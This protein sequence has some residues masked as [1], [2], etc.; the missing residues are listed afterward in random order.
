MF[1]KVIVLFASLLLFS[2]A[3]AT[4]LADIDYSSCTTE[5]LVSMAVAISHEL[6]GRTS[7]NE[8][9]KNDFLYATNQNVCYIRT[10]LGEGG[11][12]VI[13]SQI[14]EVIVTTIIDEAFVSNKSITGVVFSEGLQS[15]GNAAFP[16]TKLTGT[17]TLPT[18]LKTVGYSAF[19]HTDVTSV[20]ILSDCSVDCY[21]FEDTEIEYVYIREGAKVTLADES[22][23]FCNNLTTV[24]I[25]ASVTNI[26]KDAFMTCPKLTIVTPAGSYAE[27]YAQ[28]NFIP[29]NTV[30]YEK[31][32]A[33]YEALLL[34][35][36]TSSFE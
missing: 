6:K 19:Q 34:D 30:D 15:I 21:A 2:T 27:K 3:H 1:K 35:G 5:E 24:V 22:F 36:A 20:N 32:V 9:M 17:I 7:P 26:D 8:T 25:P 33:Q 13:P 10:Y 14:N 29:C 4:T 28:K 16:G 11:T 18:S 23:G 31:Y 12:I